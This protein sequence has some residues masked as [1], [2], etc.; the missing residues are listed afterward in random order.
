MLREGVQ[1]RSVL[2]PLKVIG[3]QF[4]KT[5]RRG[6]A[7]RLPRHEVLPYNQ[8]GAVNFTTGRDYPPPLL[9]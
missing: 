1:N 8:R 9:S 7:Y 5:P 2:N 3:Q 4:H 6:I